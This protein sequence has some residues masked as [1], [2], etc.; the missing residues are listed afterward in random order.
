LKSGPG[1]ATNFQYDLHP[2]WLR[3]IGVEPNPYMHPYLRRAGTAAGIDVDVRQHSAEYMHVADSSVDAVVTTALLCSVH[4]QTR[5]VREIKRVLK[6]GGQLIFL[7]H[8]AASRNTTLRTVQ[9]RSAVLAVHGLLRIS[10]IV[11]ILKAEMFLR[12]TGCKENFTP[13]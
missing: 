3:W 9:H 12:I 1:T 4:D 11:L 2:R 13:I 7:E 10:R 6:P 5:A 8:V